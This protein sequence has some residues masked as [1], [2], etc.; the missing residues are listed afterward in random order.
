MTKN[1]IKMSLETY[2]FYFKKSI[3]NSAIKWNEIL[4]HSRE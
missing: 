2:Y 1:K 3:S 4:I